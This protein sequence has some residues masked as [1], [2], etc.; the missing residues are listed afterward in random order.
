VLDHVVSGRPNR[1]QTIG[2]IALAAVC[3]AVVL[4]IHVFELDA[5]PEN[6][7]PDLLSVAFTVAAIAPL[8]LRRRAPLLVLISCF[9]GIWALALGQY[10]VGA[11]PVGPLIAFYTVVAWDSRRRARWA[12]ATV[13]LGVAGLV[14][15]R[16]VDL[17]TE[18][19]IANTAILVGGWI[20]GTGTRERREHAAA[21]AAAAEL[22][23]TL[24]RERADLA[25]D[26][27]QLATTRERLRISRE[28]HDV[29]GHAFSVMVVQAG[30]AERLMDS[31]PD[32]A[33][34]ALQ[35]VSATGR[36]SLADLRGMVQ[37]LRAGDDAGDDVGRPP[38]LAEADVS[39]GLADVPALVHRVRETGLAVELELDE[40]DLD[41]PD[42]DEL[43]APSHA[44]VELAAYRIVQEGLTNCLKHAQA[45]R[46]WVRI[47]RAAG[48]LEVEVRDD[49]TASA[50]AGTSSGHGLTGMRERVTIYGG[51]LEAGPSPSGGYRVRAR[52]PLPTGV[53]S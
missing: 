22:Q 40:L 45:S 28:L 6:R 7:T 38:L 4:V 2:D 5:V 50:S 20:I 27:A 43:A 25:N 36:S 49:G 30:V 9:P 1:R 16:P 53:V 48:E 34:Q 23:L 33:R 42:L 24:E 44:G 47:R 10:P 21:Q 15:L 8:V 39:P 32:Q 14:A 13:I 35:Q 46:A 17:R 52:L 37:V 11:A 12:V 18:G 51:E 19:I 3:L 26:R 31:H 29:L 41:E